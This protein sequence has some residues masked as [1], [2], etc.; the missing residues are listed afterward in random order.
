MSGD[1]MDSG[2]TEMTDDEMGDDDMDS[3]ETEMTDEAMEGD[4]ESAGD[5][6]S[7]S[8][9]GFGVV[10]AVLAVLAAAFLATCGND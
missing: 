1:D 7:E 8:T 4:T 3:E 5:S 9:P 6:T 2:E 10:L